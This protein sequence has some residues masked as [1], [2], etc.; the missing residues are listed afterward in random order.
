MGRRPAAEELYLATTRTLGKTHGKAQDAL[1]AEAA[2]HL[3]GLSAARGERS[4][5]MD[6]LKAALDAGFS[7]IDRVTG[8]SDLQTLRGAELDALI[9]RRSSGN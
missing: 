1:Y 8:S 2:F 4:K 6:W 3:A 7:A 9:A 5:A